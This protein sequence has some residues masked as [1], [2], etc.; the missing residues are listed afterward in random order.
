MGSIN[1]FFLEVTIFI[2]QGHI[3]LIKSDGKDINNNVA[4]DLHFK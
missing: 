2:Q 1:F 3:K 4:K